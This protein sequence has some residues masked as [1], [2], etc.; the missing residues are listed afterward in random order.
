MAERPNKLRE[1]LA[2]VQRQESTAEPAERT[3]T[4]TP[5]AIAAEAL[6]PPAPAPE[7]RRRRPT[8]RPATGPQTWDERVK[9][10]TFYIDRALLERLDECCEANDVNKSEFVREAITRHLQKYR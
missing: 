9:R 7:R 1:Q 2:R 6:E 4:S 10:A 8:G 5:A 3:T